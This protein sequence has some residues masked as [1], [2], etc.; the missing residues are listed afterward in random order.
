MGKGFL[1]HFYQ[2][3]G[4]IKILLAE[5]GAAFLLA[6]YYGNWA[7]YRTGL[8]DT[9][10][11]GGVDIGDVIFMMLAVCLLGWL[12]YGMVFPKVVQSSIRARLKVG[13]LIMPNPVLP[14]AEYLFIRSHPFYVAIDLI[15]IG[16]AIFLW[17]MTPWERD[18]RWTFEQARAKGMLLMALFFPLFRLV[19]WYLFRRQPKEHENLQYQAVIKNIWKPIAMFYLFFLVPLAIIFLVMAMTKI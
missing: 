2:I 12:M 13:S 5:F 16:I 17:Y 4:V 3:G 18:P 14:P 7:V 8:R 1:S 11:A 10:L 9:W 15:T 6:G 19:C